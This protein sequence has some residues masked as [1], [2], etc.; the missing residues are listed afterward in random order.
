M[1]NFDVSL[2]ILSFLCQLGIKF[3]IDDFGTGY[4]SLI[5]LRRLPIG[6]VKIDRSFI[7]EIELS[8]ESRAIVEGIILMAHK[9]DLKVIAEG[10]ETKR[11]LEI[12]KEIGCDFAQ[13]YLFSKP[14]PKT[15][16]EKLLIERKITV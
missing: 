8:K 4:S 1:K 3:L 12:L 15:E 9:L 7:S 11:E 13:G 6:G 2:K 16:I 10:V 14:V 5:Y